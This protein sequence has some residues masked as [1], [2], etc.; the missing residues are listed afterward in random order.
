MKSLALTFILSV[1]TCSAY[2]MDFN[3]IKSVQLFDDSLVDFQK[4]VSFVQFSNWN[5]NKIDYLELKDNSIIDS[6]DITKVFFKKPQV[7]RQAMR[8]MAVRG[9]DSG[10]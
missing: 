3:S 5:R 2:S 9:D 8:F 7:M 4:D 1:I 10:G 6:T